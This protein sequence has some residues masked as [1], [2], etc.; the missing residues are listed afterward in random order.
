MNSQDFIV[1]PERNRNLPDL[2]NLADMIDPVAVER[3]NRI[4]DSSG[5]M[6]VVSSAWRCGLSVV[7]L[8]ELLGSRGFRGHIIGKTP[9][10][11]GKTPRF[12]GND[13]EEEIQAWLDKHKDKDVES[14]VI[15]DD[16]KVDSL[17]D[18]QVLTSFCVGL[19]DEH[20]EKALEILTFFGRNPFPL[21][22]GS[23]Q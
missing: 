2:E 23:S 1:R 15:L 16:G 6:V 19:L 17:F 7:E 4:L 3:L 21:S 14:F 11:I 8:R 9:Q 20:V 10:T 13:R 5:A 22:E 18:H 12:Q